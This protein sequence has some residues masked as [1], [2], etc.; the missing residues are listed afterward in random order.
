MKFSEDFSENRYFIFEKNHI[1]GGKE[2]VKGVISYIASLFWGNWMKVFHPHPKTNR[3]YHV[4]IGAI[5]KNEAPYLKEWIE[6][7]RIVGVEHFYLYNNCSDDNY[8]DVL[9]PYIKQGVVTLIDW[10][11]QQAQMQCYADII[12]RFHNETE[13]LGLID[14]DEFV[15]PKSDLTISEVLQSF[16]YAPSVLIYW[17]IFGTSGLMNR[18]RAGLVTEDFT[19]SWPKYYTVGKCFLNMN[20]NFDMS[21]PRNTCIHHKAWGSY[22]GLSYPPVNVFGYPVVNST[23]RY[24]KQPIPLQINHYF[25]K[26]YM[27][28]Q[29]KKSKGDVY[30]KLNPHDEEY[31]FAHEEWCQDVDYSAYRFLIK[32][33]QAMDK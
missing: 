17:R 8:M 32:L 1:G 5:F 29:E 21:S 3:K 14:I 4:T 13:W 27:E 20:Y 12:K 2:Y 23:H 7:H 28:Y 15:I 11:Y 24:N 30:F 22:H 10:P 26:S 6:F 33:K 16:R 18:E 19:V 31:F 9:Y 25:T